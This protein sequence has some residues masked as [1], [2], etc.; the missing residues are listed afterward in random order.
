MRILVILLAL[1][2]LTV[3]GLTPAPVQPVAE[4]VADDFDD[5]G[6]DGAWNTVAALDV[7]IFLPEG[8]T[9]EDIQAEDACYRARSV[10]GEAS[11]TILYPVEGGAAGEVVSAAGKEARLIRGDDGSLTVTLAL[12]EDRLAGF[13]FERSSE[14][15]LSEALALKIAGSCIDVW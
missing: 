1:A 7:E 4:I 12:S 10:D 13:R 2:M 5:D 15:A 6:Y 3:T 9:G 11:L 8:W 14:D